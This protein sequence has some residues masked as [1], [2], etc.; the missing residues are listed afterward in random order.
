MEVGEQVPSPLR[1]AIF[2]SV[3]FLS[4][5][6]AALSQK[7]AHE[8]KQMFLLFRPMN[9]IEC[10]FIFQKDNVE[11]SFSF[12]IQSF[13]RLDCLVKLEQKLDEHMKSFGGYQKR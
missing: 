7:A 11:S 3:H 8:S 10:M 1:Q 6:V 9:F 5:L 4:L 2:S 13:R 12:E